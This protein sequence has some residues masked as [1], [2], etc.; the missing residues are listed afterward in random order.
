ML[1]LFKNL[2]LLYFIQLITPSKVICE[3]GLTAPNFCA[4][5]E[6]GNLIIS[7]HSFLKGGQ[8]IFLLYYWRILPTLPH[9]QKRPA[10]QPCS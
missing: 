5:R 6:I 8:V 10:V 2:L 3:H 9:A 7:E 4:S 1:Q